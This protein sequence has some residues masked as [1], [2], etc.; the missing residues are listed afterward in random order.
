MANKLTGSMSTVR[1]CL[2]FIITHL[3]HDY[4]PHHTQG[5]QSAKRASHK[6][7]PYSYPGS[8]G[9]H[10]GGAS[11]KFSGKYQSSVEGPSSSGSYT[12]KFL[13]L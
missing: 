3:Q 4:Q 12:G 9:Q 10:Q 11:K 13:T 5:S 8:K 1:L 7:N 2:I 6:F